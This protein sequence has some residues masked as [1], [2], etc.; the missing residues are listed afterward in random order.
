MRLPSGGTG[1]TREK[2]LSFAF[3]G[4]PHRGFEGDTVASALLAA[5]VRT[6]GRSFKYHRPRG[7]WGHGVEEPNAIFDVKLA[8]FH[9][10]NARGTTTPLADGLVVRSINARPDASRDRFGFLD[11]F[12]KFIPAGFYYKTFMWPSWERFE[13]RIR[14]MAGLGEIDREW[15]PKA[16]SSHVHDTCDVLVVGAGNSGLRAALA[17][18]RDG[19]SVTVVDEGFAP[20]GQLLYRSR[21]ADGEHAEE[22]LASTLAELSRLGVTIMSRST[23]YGIYDHNLVCVAELKKATNPPISH[24]I[25]PKQIVLATGAIERPLVFPNNDRPGIMS[26][27]SALFYLRRHGV[28]VGERIVIASNNDSTAEVAEA[29]RVVGAN[30]TEVSSVANVRGKN[31]VEAVIDENGRSIPADAL[32]VSGG[33]SPT[34]HLFC[35]AKGKLAWSDERAAFVPKD[36]V[37]G[38]KV[39]GSANG[40]FRW[41]VQASW[42]TKPTKER[43]WIDFQN[44]VTSKDVALAARENFRSVEH[45]KR[46]TTLGMATDQGKTSNVNGLAAL[47]AFTG[48]SIA[49]TGTTTFRPPYTPVSMMAFTGYRHGQL[50]NPVRRLA[51]ETEHRAAGA[52]FGEYGGWLRPAAY[53][54]DIQSEALRAREG[55]GI[56]DA[57]PLGKVEVIG[58]D[59]GLLLD[60]NGYGKVSTLKPGRIRYGLTLNENGSVYDDGVIARLDETRFLVSCSS[61]HVTGVHLRLEDIRQDLFDPTRLSIHNATSRWATLTVTGPK[62]R[63]L[64]DSLSLGLDLG[65]EAFPHMSWRMATFEGGPV[66]LAR[67]SFSG[68]L[69]FEVSVPQSK[70]ASLFCALREAGARFNATMLGLEAL[71]ILRAEKGYIVIGKD[72]DGLTLP[73]DLGIVGPRD[74]RTDEFVGRR[75]LFTE[76]AQEKKRRQFTGLSITDGG[77]PLATGA[78]AIERVTGKSRSIGFVTSSYFSPTIG[79]PIALGLI[80][81][82]MERQGEII[83]M[84]HLGAVR[85][86]RVSAAC[87]FDPEGARLNA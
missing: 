11:R 13:P 29:F 4:K 48:R 80:E 60:F 24:R 2:E 42:P 37:Q 51:L 40:D 76:W 16:F 62:S 21:T 79:K 19:R 59:A 3:D 68:D 84:Q 22:W 6:V 63:S 7:I 8:G 31:R 35:Q 78:H 52:I 26:A 28:R 14:A 20:G 66:R 43:A 64:L 12:A 74:K 9:E 86:A 75:S 87:A 83:E 27:A 25:R 71:M 82:A 85:K 57:S 44:D 69:S 49:E 77:G 10:P 38:V 55:V 53:D 46:Y 73:H 56:F 23:A 1:I 54:R 58:P 33:Y 15:A 47:A 67:V 34:V 17:A 81:N 65:N 18:A 70:A 30:V 36:E 72:T 39:I 41:R 50:F 32:L 61:S 45:L 5:G